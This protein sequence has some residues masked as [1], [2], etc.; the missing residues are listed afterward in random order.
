MPD[1]GTDM[2]P[3]IPF[4]PSLEFIIAITIIASNNDELWLEYMKSHNTPYW[5]SDCNILNED[6]AVL[7]NH[8]VYGYV[9]QYEQQ[10]QG[11]GKIPLDIIKII[12]K[13]VLEI[14]IVPVPSE[15][16][17]PSWLSQWRLSKWDST[18]WA[19]HPR[20]TIDYFTGYD[21]NQETDENETGGRL[22]QRNKIF[23]EGEEWGEL[24]VVE[25][26]VNEEDQ[27]IDMVNRG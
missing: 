21:D 19:G 13:Y 10:R 20:N 3:T 5:E 24:K 2:S 25:Y 22:N 11:S 14:A 12:L 9:H 8:A 6:A 23:H 18:I 26:E 7:Q 15:S 16:F 27:D 1:L 17:R 4:D